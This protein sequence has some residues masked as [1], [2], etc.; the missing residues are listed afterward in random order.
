MRAISNRSQDTIPRLGWL[1]TFNDMVTL[2]MVFFV[3][4]FAM[5]TIDVGKI[6]NFQSAMQ[7]ALG[8]LQAGQQTGVSV[9]DGRRSSTATGDQQA[10]PADRGRADQKGA[11]NATQGR[12][13]TPSE[14]IKAMAATLDNQYGIDA[15]YT[16][17]GLL[18]TLD[19]ELLFELG[20]ADINPQGA[21]ILD[22]VGAA[23]QK[24]DWPLRVEGHT[25]SLPINTPQFPSNWELSTAR[26]VKVVKYFSTHGTIDAHR[27]SAVGYGAAKPRAANDTPINRAR[28][29]RVE[30]VVEVQREQ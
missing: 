3:L 24:V 8:V 11:V 16:A 26:A 18:I 7:S 1:T 12:T 9:V 29:R 4:L 23:L 17:Q 27:L 14:L 20:K 25:D 10:T 6:K 21:S 15:I 5:G 2:L 19:N 22:H 28:N 13:A 30:I